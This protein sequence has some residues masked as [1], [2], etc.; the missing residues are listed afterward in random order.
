MVNLCE[1]KGAGVWGMALCLAFGQAAE[2]SPKIFTF[3]I[4]PHN[5]AEY[6]EFL[7]GRQVTEIDDLSN[8]AHSRHV[9]E[10]FLFQRALHDSN[11]NCVVHYEANS[12]LRTH[13]RAIADVRAGRE[14]AHPVAGFSNDP[15][16]LDGVSLSEAILPASDFHVGLYTHENRHD[17]LSIDDPAQVRDLRFT[18]GRSWVVDNQVID[19]YGFRKVVADGWSS[20]IKMIAASR[21]DVIMQ[22]ISSQ[23]DFSITDSKTGEKLLPIPSIKLLFGAARQYFVSEL[24]PDGS[25]LLE[26]LNAGIKKLSDSGLLTSANIGSGLLNPMTQDWFV[27]D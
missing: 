15:R 10:L 12:N 23:P 20:A 4:Q 16:Y 27:I 24:H 21:A 22:P 3:N 2:A 6:N 1:I 8:E 17:I 14:V 13:V 7:D 9:M 25:F 5:L 11:C 19:Q 26:H 18:A